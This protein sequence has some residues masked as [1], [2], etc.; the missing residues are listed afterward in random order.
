MKVI[1]HDRK[2]ME[3]VFL[4]LLVVTENVNDELGHAIGLQ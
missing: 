2:F 3:E 4:L 1:W